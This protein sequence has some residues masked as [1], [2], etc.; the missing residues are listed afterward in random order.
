M[1]TYIDITD[2]VLKTNRLTLRPFHQEDLEDFYQYASVDG[3][4]Q[5]AGWRPHSSK[6]ETQ[7]ILDSFVKKKKTFALEYQGKVIG[8]LGI[9]EYN[10]EKFPEFNDKKCRQLGFVLA[11]EHWGKGFMVEAVNEVLCYLFEDIG[12]DLILC[13]YFLKNKQSQRVQEKCGFQ[14]YRKSM[15]Q[16]E[17]GDIEES[18]DNILRKEEWK[19]NN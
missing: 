13:G 7:A 17:M 18:V 2:V 10:V 11:K 8:S 12:L 1:N 4:G 6:E 5:M 14:P 9:E 15:H 3:V 19:Q 16:T